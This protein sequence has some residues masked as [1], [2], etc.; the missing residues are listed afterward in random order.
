[1]RH[2]IQHSL[3]QGRH[4]IKYPTQPQTGAPYNQ[5]KV[6][7]MCYWKPYAVTKINT[8]SVVNY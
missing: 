4:T 3:K 7:K 8:K 5:I 1:M 6:I 2:N